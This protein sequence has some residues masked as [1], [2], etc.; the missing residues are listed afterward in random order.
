[1]ATLAQRKSSSSM[2]GEAEEA[3]LEIKVMRMEIGCSDAE[4]CMYIQ[5][6][7]EVVTP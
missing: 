3:P 2:R 5:Y 4:M 6:T 1:M 7:V